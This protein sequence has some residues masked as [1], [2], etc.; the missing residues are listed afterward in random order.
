MKI[1]K[2]RKEFHCLTIGHREREIKG[3]YL[4]GANV[5]HP[6]G[7]EMKRMDSCQKDYKP[8]LI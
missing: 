7:I 4:S 3:K 5:L 2:E 6:P 1:K 8:A